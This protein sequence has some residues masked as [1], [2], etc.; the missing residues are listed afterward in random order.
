MRLVAFMLSIARACWL[1]PFLGRLVMSLLLMY[2]RPRPSQLFNAA[3]GCGATFCQLTRV[4]LAIAAVKGRRPPASGHVPFLIVPH[5][6]CRFPSS[7]NLSRASS[8]CSVAHPHLPSAYSSRPSTSN[9]LW[10]LVFLILSST[11]GSRSSA[12]SPGRG[13][14]WELVHMDVLFATL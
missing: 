14:F 9:Y 5:V 2:A 8:T 1:A 4:L 12:Y 13:C 3:C 11:T 7:G 6:S 10:G